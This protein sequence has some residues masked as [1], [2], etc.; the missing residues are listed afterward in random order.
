MNLNKSITH[1]NVHLMYNAFKK[2]IIIIMLNTEYVIFKH[3]CSNIINDKDDFQL[4][5]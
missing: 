4:E 5:L 2:N 1:Y 3:T